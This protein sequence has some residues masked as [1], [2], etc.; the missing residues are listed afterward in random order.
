[1]EVHDRRGWPGLCV[2]APCAGRSSLQ[3]VC[4]RVCSAPLASCPR[5]AALFAVI[6]RGGGCDNNPSLLAFCA[7]RRR[8]PPRRLE[9]PPQPSF[10]WFSHG[11]WNVERH[12][13]SD[14]V[15]WT[16]NT[17]ST[18]NPTNCSARFSTEIKV[19]E[20][21]RVLSVPFVWATNFRINVRVPSICYARPPYALLMCAAV[22]PGSSGHSK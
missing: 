16:G 5:L 22:I 17:P 10:V 2:A 15:H 7:G 12:D 1:M 6:R 14:Q 21:L 13:S 18:M 9:Y 3:L 4:T 19:L 8:R 20:Q 11:L